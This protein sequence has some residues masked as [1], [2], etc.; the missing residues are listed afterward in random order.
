MEHTPR[1]RALVSAALALALVLAPLPLSPAEASWV[2]APVTATVS[3]GCRASAAYADSAFDSAGVSRSFVT[4]YGGTCPS[5]RIRY[6]T[7]SGT[8]G[9]A[10]ASPY[11]GAV[12]GVADDG[13]TT[14]LLYRASDGTRVG[15]RTR[16]GAWKTSVRV[17]THRSGSGDIAA[18]GGRWW[19]VWSEASGSLASIYNART[20]GGTTGRTRITTLRATDTHPALAVTPRG[21]AFLAF[22]RRFASTGR[23][24][25]AVFRKA[26]P[27]TPWSL[28]YQTADG[29]NHEPDVLAASDTSVTAA[30][31]HGTRIHMTTNRT[32]SFVRRAFATPGSRPRVAA[33]AGRYVF[34]WTKAGSPSEIVLA[35]RSSNVTVERTITSRA[36]T[37]RRAAAV[38]SRN[39]NAAVTVLTTS[40]LQVVR[41]V[42][43]SVA[44]FGGLGTWVDRLDYGLDPATTVAAMK[45]RGVRTLYL[46]TGKFDQSAD[47][48]EAAKVGR[49]LEAAHA[50]GIKVVGW[51][52]PGYGGYLERD[53]R[54]TLAIRS[55]RSPAGH[56]FDA[57]GIDIERRGAATTAT[58]NADVAAHL[59]RVRA[60]VGS[61][62]PVSA[63][64]QSPV[65]M[66]LAPNTWAGFPWA[67][68]GTYA[69]VVQ[70]MGYWTFRSD[71]ATNPAHCP[72][73]YS[74]DNVILARSYT[75]L[76]VHEV[77]GIHTEPAGRVVTD[78]DVR[79]FVRGTLVAGAIGGSMYDYRTTLASYWDDLASLN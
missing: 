47:V 24:E 1:P 20:I 50:K 2:S 75:G 73:A 65:A 14:W 60:G 37:A 9:A 26:T 52:F 70:P 7:Q 42:R 29:D 30:W 67:T 45:A 74:R 79:D 44:A 5:A 77:G 43:P 40:S 34:A 62:Y 27:S 57:L 48:I 28:K 38:G 6:A 21:V 78:Q 31:R 39:G 11:Y 36:T 72:Y 61:A 49:W 17:T 56:R 41:Q 63:I 33:S 15:G 35:E 46:Q 55:F 76:P 54:R 59:R 10:V 16:A 22:A 19:A 23:R 64:V 3:A 71:C 58:F 68:I 8:R 4:W 53:V 66:K 25:I 18:V 12:L 69:D 13:T 51:Y 32:G